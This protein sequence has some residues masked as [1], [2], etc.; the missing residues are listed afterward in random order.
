[1]SIKS[2]TGLRA[3]A[4]VLLV[5]GFESF[6]AMGAQSGGP[7][8][9]VDPMIGSHGAGGNS[10]RIFHDSFCVFF[11]FLLALMVYNTV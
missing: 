10:L 2:L 4:I 7:S 9:F 3:A 1:M 5:G 8:A 11:S 6:V